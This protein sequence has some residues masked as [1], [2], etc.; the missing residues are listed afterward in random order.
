MDTTPPTDSGVLLGSAYG[1]ITIDFSQIEAD[2]Q[3]TLTALE[4]SLT[5]GFSALSATAAQLGGQLFQAAQS[6]M[7][8]IPAWV[9]AVI[10]APLA[11][12]VADGGPIAGAAGQLGASL[13]G[14][15]E[16]GLGDVGAWVQQTIL[17]PIS[18][19]L[20]GISGLLPSLPSLPT[21]PG[22]AEG[23]LFHAGQPFIA[24]E[25]GRAELIVPST[26]GMVVNHSQLATALQA[27]GGAGD[28]YNLSIHM[29]S[30]A[31]DVPLIIQAQS[32]GEEV[33]RVLRSR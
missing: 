7:P 25:G 9:Q 1:E 8:D 22:F 32:F 16:A 21:I 14:W 23:G 33:L 11:G 17:G 10:Q 12:Q 4:R 27:L 30:L 24:G 18:Q 2:F 31:P 26:S 28:T 13:L 3:T 19:A 15:I 29:G 20:G 5:A 6:G